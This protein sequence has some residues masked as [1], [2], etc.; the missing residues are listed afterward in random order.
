MTG[1]AGRYVDRLQFHTN[2][3]RTSE[4]I[5]GGGGTPFRIDFP[6]NA[7]LAAF[8][9]RSDAYLDQIGF[10]FTEDPIVSVKV[11]NWDYDASSLHSAA[12]QADVLGTH[13]VANHSGVEQEMIA[14]FSYAVNHTVTVS[15]SLSFTEGAKVT[16]GTGNESLVKFEAELSFSA[17]QEFTHGEQTTISKMVEISPV[18][19]VP[20]HREIE[21][22]QIGK[23]GRFDIPWSGT[24][25]IT[26]RSGATET[27]A[28]TGTFKG[29]G[30][31]RSKTQFGQDRGISP[32]APPA[33]PNGVLSFKHQKQ[34]V[35]NSHI[36]AMMNYLTP[37][38]EEWTARIEG[39]GFHHTKRGASSG[40]A[41]QV[42]TY[43]SWDGTGWLARVDV[44]NKRFRHW[45]VN[46]AESSGHVSANM[47]YK[48]WSRDN[49][50]ATL[51]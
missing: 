17:T 19:R 18:V 28:L 4:D 31:F 26:R 46:T 29:V 27:Q 51:V 30:V 35:A 47:H 39:D 33:Q 20:P 50:D 23:W 42:I 14:R 2:K 48:A 43:L 21:V 49:W 37:S 22:Q 7:S 24:A 34:N 13:F 11:V 45:R 32:P 15:T 44:A 9:G 6:N 38:G 1:R 16:F 10:Y 3:G 8:Y 25:V 40:H 5:P 12:L 36:S 41:N